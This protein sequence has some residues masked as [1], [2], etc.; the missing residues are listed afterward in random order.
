M[1][2][3][4]GDSELVAADPKTLGGEVIR[5]ISSLGEED[6]EEDDDDDEEEEEEEAVEMAKAATVLQSTYRGRLA[7]GSPGSRSKKERG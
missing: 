7:R 1:Y 6:E 2:D 3:P 5:G 4:I